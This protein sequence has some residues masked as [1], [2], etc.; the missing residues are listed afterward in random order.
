MEFEAYSVGICNASVCTSLPVNA[1]E[2]RLNVE[3]PTGI[4]MKWKLSKDKTFAGGQ[5]MPCDCRDYPGNKHYL[6]HC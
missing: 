5:P 2:Q 6:F 4:G 1:A 3:H